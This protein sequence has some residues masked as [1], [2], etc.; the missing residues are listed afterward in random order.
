MQ[1]TLAI[2]AMGLA[3]SIVDKAEY[4][5]FNYNDDVGAQ[6]DQFIA[7]SAAWAA[8]AVAVLGIFGL[9][10]VTTRPDDIKAA[11]LYLLILFI[12]VWAVMLSIGAGAVRD[13]LRL[14]C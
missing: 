11:H 10:G 9:F 8:G 12:D 4:Y 13:S 14:T 2:A 5:D 3:I 7:L 1:I 6:S